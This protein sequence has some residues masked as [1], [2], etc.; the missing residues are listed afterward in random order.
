ML[1]SRMDSA[2]AHEA[3]DCTRVARVTLAVGRLRLSTETADHG[4]DAIHPRKRVPS[5]DFD[6]RFGGRLP[7]RP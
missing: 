5:E 4:L 6:P 3:A 7:P 1:G 2:P